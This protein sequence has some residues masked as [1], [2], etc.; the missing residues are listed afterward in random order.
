M[1]NLRKA[2]LTGTFEAARAHHALDVRARWERNGGRIDVYGAI[3]KLKLPLMFQPLESLLGA[4]LVSPSPGVLINTRRPLSVRRYTAAHELGHHWLKHQPS[5]D[6]QDM[7]ERVP[8][9]ARAGYDEQE[10]EADAFAIAFLLPTWFMAGEMRRHG[11]QASAMREPANIYQ[12]ALRAGVSYQTTCY[13]LKSHRVINAAACANAVAV[14]PKAIKQ[15]LVQGYEPANWRFD[16][17]H[18][19]S[20]DD[21]LFVEAAPGDVVEISLTEHSG[22]GY[23][24]DVAGI[25]RSDLEVIGD[26]R[27][28]IDPDGTVGGHVVRRLT[29]RAREPGVGSVRF[30]ERRPWETGTEPLSSYQF[31]Y[32]ISDVGEPGLL[33]SQREQML[34]GLG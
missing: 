24:W 23:L 3:D 5:L 27:E 34:G 13:A 4:Y 1:G 31:S 22:G 12:L 15:S 33:K 7:I 17:W 10:V 20:E 26:R 6:G 19:G 14:Q 2:I 25:V 8:F 16:A 32:D 29:A 11:W 21:G 28:R 30:V 18:L 9:A